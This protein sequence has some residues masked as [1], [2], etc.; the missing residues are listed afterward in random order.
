LD[1]LP[2]LARELPEEFNQGNSGIIKFAFGKKHSV[3]KFRK[4][5]DKKTDFK[6]M[7]RL[8]CRQL[9]EKDA[10]RLSLLLYTNQMSQ[11]EK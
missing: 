8:N 9:L 6:Y 7:Q 2:L 3:T 5:G 4:F 1:L 10:L 11:N